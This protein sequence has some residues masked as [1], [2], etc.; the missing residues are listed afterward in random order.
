LSDSAV[1][2]RFNNHRIDNHAGI[3]DRGKTVDANEA[4][5]GPVKQ[6]RH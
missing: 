1:N 5:S 6:L 3:I 4:G 2:L